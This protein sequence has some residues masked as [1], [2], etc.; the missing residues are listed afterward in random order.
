VSDGPHDGRK[1]GGR[2]TTVADCELGT[3]LALVPSVM[4]LRLAVIGLCCFVLGLAAVAFAARPD[5]SAHGGVAVAAQRTSATPRAERVIV[6]FVDSLSSELARDRTLMP[7]LSTLALRGAAFEVEPCRDQLTFLCLQAAF[8]GRDESRLLALA[9]NFDPHRRTS[10]DTLI[11][12]L[13][14]RGGRVVAVGSNDFAA[15]EA[16]LTASH[17][18][19]RTEESEQNVL[20]A[21]SA[22]E[23]AAPPALTLIGLSR[24]DLV[25]H[26]HGPDSAEYRAVFQSIDRTI[27][28]IDQRRAPGTHLV[29]LG[30]HGHDRTGSHLPGGESKTW[31][32]YLGPAIR[33]GVAG[34]M[35]ITAHRTLLGLL[36]GLPVPARHEGPPLTQVFEPSWVDR[37]LGGHLPATAP[38]AA[39]PGAGWQRFSVLLALVF[40]AFGLFY[41]GFLAWGS[42]RLAAVA[43][44]V[45]L[46]SAAVG[47]G[48][49]Y[50]ALRRLVHDHG[51]SP[52]RSLYLLLPAAL[53][54]ATAVL[55]RRQ[56]WLRPAK[57]GAWL[58]TGAAAS[59]L[60]T[61]ICLFP[62]AYFYGSSR[63]V[64]TISIF[65]VAALA[66][67]SWR[68]AAG[69]KRS[70]T[71]LLAASLFA[72]ATLGSFVHVGRADSS[73]PTAGFVL[74]SAIYQGSAWLPLIAAK[75]AVFGLL[76]WKSKGRRP[77]DLAATASLLTASLLV[78][79]GSA[80][81]HR[82]VY[83]VV[84]G[85]LLVSCRSATRTAP[86]AQMAAGLFLLNHLYGA[87]PLRVAPVEL[88]LS[89]T[90]AA[91]V[92]W[93]QSSMR[94]DSREWAAGLTLATSAYLLLW[95]LFGFRLSGVD[96]RFMLGW[97]PE[98][99]YD[100]WW[101]LIAG[102]TLLKF[103]T[104]YWLLGLLAKQHA[105]RGRAA[106]LALSVIGARALVLSLMV[107]AYALNHS[108]RS[109]LATDMLSE[110]ALVT[111]CLPWIASWALTRD[112]RG[113][114]TA[115][116]EPPAARGLRRSL[117]SGASFAAEPASG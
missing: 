24:G 38:A 49:G 101:W 73:A 61:L 74:K 84:A 30:D 108:M 63:A 79:L 22:L 75:L 44:A 25:A 85:L 59:L 69:D 105:A 11:H 116:L 39:A 81:I 52:E 60:V 109:A 96:F 5:P 2:T 87:D 42:A 27:A 17:Y 50:E 65:V 66:F 100:D 16:A 92:A 90:S 64:V 55:L 6:V 53:G 32:V 86:A 113:A 78:Q 93:E 12:A 36:L 89:A 8:S 110:L 58:P 1:L 4:R 51:F 62:S 18:I 88:L 72:A 14:A 71:A 114:P 111:L 54:F 28:A 56:R 94:R 82:Y 99:H 41:F 102:G 10:P 33:S 21:W 13:A 45:A 47:A 31:S 40:T 46:S 9:D 19:P 29:V 103:A 15:F 98:R 3:R 91:L 68:D 106:L 43:G 57:P 7:A 83:A 20:A 104:P 76:A 34:K 95:P 70:R 35:S 117:H 26:A 80:S 67:D 112:D 37:A 115:P 48:H 97:I 23:A 77:L 107:S